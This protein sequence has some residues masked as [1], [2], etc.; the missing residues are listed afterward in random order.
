VRRLAHALLALVHAA[1][2][3]KSETVKWKRVIDAANLQL[4]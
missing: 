4:D 2:F 3:F 1:A